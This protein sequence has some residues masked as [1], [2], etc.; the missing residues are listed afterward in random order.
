M[1][2]EVDPRITPLHRLIQ[3]GF[4]GAIMSGEKHFIM[5]MVKADAP[6]EVGAAWAIAEY[7]HR[8]AV[9]L[10]STPPVVQA[11]WTPQQITETL[12]QHMDAIKR[13]KEARH[14]RL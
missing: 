1:T 12:Q 11:A 2:D 4:K 13:E 6:V 3:Q 14:A 10:S 5:A 9:V 8:I 7:L